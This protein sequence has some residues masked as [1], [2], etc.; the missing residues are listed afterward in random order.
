MAEVFVEWHPSPLLISE[1]LNELATLLEDMHVP[2]AASVEVVGRSFLQKFEDQGPG[3]AP[4]AESYANYA[5]AHNK[6]ILWQSGDLAESMTN[7]ANYLI[8]ENALFWT[9][10]GAPYYWIFHHEGTV[11]MPQ[12]DWIEIDEATA[13]ELAAIFGKYIDAS[14][15]ET[16]W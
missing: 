1:Q 10:G 7:E 11:K 13:S 3:W 15:A 14:I 16:G 5:A 12:R 8:A 9:G 2:L 4:W 6:G